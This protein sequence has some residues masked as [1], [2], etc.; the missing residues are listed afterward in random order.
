MESHEKRTVDNPTARA[1]NRRRTAESLEEVKAQV[2]AKE[3][4]DRGKEE[5]AVQYI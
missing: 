1:H 2:E 5:H 3:P 4:H